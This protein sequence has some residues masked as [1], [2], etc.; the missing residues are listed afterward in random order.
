MIHDAAE[1][2]KKEDD[3]SLKAHIHLKLTAECLAGYDRL[4]IAAALSN[5]KLNAN[6]TQASHRLERDMFTLW[7]FACQDLIVVPFIQS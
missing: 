5:M 4:R 7:M 6:T 2:I 3:Y 1:S